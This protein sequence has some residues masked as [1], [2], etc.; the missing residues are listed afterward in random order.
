MIFEAMAPSESLNSELNLRIV[1][2]I[3]NKSQNIRESHLRLRWRSLFSVSC[4]IRLLEV[5]LPFGRLR[6]GFVVLFYNAMVMVDMSPFA[7]S[8]VF[9]EG[10]APCQRKSRIFDISVIVA[11]NVY[12]SVAVSCFF[13]SF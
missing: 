2:I 12:C 1:L 5:M 6:R 11:I 9:K 8:E 4:T 7:P 13:H 10:A 3:S